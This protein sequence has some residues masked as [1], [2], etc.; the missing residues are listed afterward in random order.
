M[1]V[2]AYIEAVMN[3]C[4][5]LLEEGKKELNANNAH[6]AMMMLSRALESC[7]CGRNNSLGEILFYLGVSFMKLGQPVYAKRC[8]LNAFSVRG[9]NDSKEAGSPEWQLFYT[10]QV[11]RYLNRKRSFAFDTLAEGDMVRDLIQTAWKE[12]SELPTLKSLSYDDRIAY[13]FSLR[14]VFPAAADEFGQAQSARTGR[15][16]PYPLKKR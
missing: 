14:I 10:V 7:D 4:I 6:K 15:I 5:R 16:V 8:W 13:Y 1:F 12:I 9:S 3:E 2:S 11:S